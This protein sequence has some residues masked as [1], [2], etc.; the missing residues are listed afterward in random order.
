MHFVPERELADGRPF[1][2]LGPAAGGAP[3]TALQLEPGPGLRLPP[4]LWSDT[5]TGMVLRLLASERS[6]V[7]APLVD[8]VTATVFDGDTALAMWA[9]THPEEAAKREARLRAAARACAFG[10]AHDDE[11][12]QIACYFRSLAEDIGLEDAADLYQAALP[13]VGELLDHPRAF[14]LVWIGDYSD[15]IQSTSM[16]NS[17]AV[18][19]DEHPDLDLTVLRTPLRLHD[20]TRLTAAA[21][22]RVLTVRSEN[23]YMLEYRRESWVRHPT[24]RPQPRIDTRPLAARL[25]LFERGEGHWRSQPCHLPAPVMIFDD[26]RGVASP[27]LI[28]AETVVDEVIGFLRGNARNSELLWTPDLQDPPR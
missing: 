12:V 13:C 8:A 22:T 27:S 7:P 16:L 14:D 26:G 6:A 21:H 18:E 10:V 9:L 25:S 23:T 20:L 28:D 11:L 4:A 17:G 2:R 3:A 24:G 15:V 5:V 19:I 1:L